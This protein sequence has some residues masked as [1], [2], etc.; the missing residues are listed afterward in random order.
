MKPEES[1][2]HLLGIT[3]SKAKMYEYDVPQEDHITVYRDPSNLFPLSIGLLGDLAAHLNSQQIDEISELKANLQF[4]AQFFD[5]FFQARLS[6]GL[7]PYLFLLGSAAYYLCDLPGSSSVLVKSLSDDGLD[8][9]CLGLE[10]LLL[11]LLKGKFTT[12]L[13]VVP[14][15]YEQNIQTLSEG[16]SRYFQTGIAPEEIFANASVL[17]GLAYEAGNPR[18]LLFA[19]VSV[20][21]TRKRV[22]NSTWFRLPEYSRLPVE[23]WS[24]TL[25]KSTFITEL[26]PGQRRLGE[27]GVF[28]GKSAIVQLPTSAGKTKATEILI[29][30]SFLAR[31][32]LLAVIVAPFRALCHEIRNDLVRAFKDEPIN[33]NEVSD[34][35]QPDFDLANITE[36]PQVLVV[37]PEKLVHVLRYNPELAQQIK[38]LIYD[39]GHQFDDQTRGVTYELLVTSL[40]Q[41]IPADAQTIL[42]SAVISNPDAIGTWLNGEDSLVIQGNDLTP[43]YRTLAFSSWVDPRGRLWFVDPANPDTEEF[44]V[45]RVIEQQTLQLKPRETAERVFPIRDDGSDVALFLGL[46]LVS[47]GSVAIFVGLK[48]SVGTLCRRAL[49]VY[50]RGLNIERP[51]NF[52]VQ[53]EIDRLTFLY[54]QNLGQNA[55]TAQSA[56]LGVFAHHNNIPQG[57]RLSV[58]YAVKNE[59]TKFVICTSTL[60]QGVNLPLRYLIVTSMYQGGEQIKVRDFHNLIGRAG[61]AGMFTE[62]SILFADPQIYLERNEDGWRWQTARSLL[63]RNN[64]E[65]ST[66]A[67]AQLLNPIEHEYDSSISIGPVDFVNAYIEGRVYEVLE[68]AIPESA[69]NVLTPAAFQ[70]QIDLRGDIIA[71]IES[72]LM[73]F[74][75]ENDQQLQQVEILRLA[76]ETLAYF[77]GGDDN[78]QQLVQIFG[79]LA[80]NIADKIPDSPKRKAFA[81]TFLG[82]KGSLSVEAWVADHIEALIAT[83]TQEEILNVLW[84]LI[85]QS[86][87]NSTA[88]RL[89]PAELLQ[90]IS[91][92]WIQGES[93]GDMLQPLEEHKAR[94]GTARNAPFVKVEH[95]VDICEN[96]F[97]FD[98]MLIVGAVTEVIQVVRPS[99]TD[100]LVRNLRAIQ[101]RLKYGLPAPLPI[102]IYEM[103]FADRILAMEL[104]S[105]LPVSSFLKEDILAAFNTNIEQVRVLLE[106]Y[107]SYFTIVLD[108]LPGRR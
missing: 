82:V 36:T 100:N 58:E 41:T 11:W 75:N 64:S 97:A 66:S 8:L 96:G 102:A 107:P 86:L 87:Q 45:P 92:R 79:I 10:N 55:I 48:D 18:Q 30:S 105:I 23:Q 83:D 50:E 108:E 85:S 77:L 71:A 57:I 28:S 91:V 24:A 98:S 93:F 89:N 34:V 70:D 78:K 2:R 81:R 9:G 7:D 51:A 49:D 76:S 26:W 3:R 15:P 65:A 43:T 32:S 53:N 56:A 35:L 37:T 13:N 59:L 104:S 33:V 20:A 103:G 106:K 84:D 12:A 67:L 44:Y 68:E 27:E 74:W 63:D 80:E 31:R 22:E 47:K 42:I 5:N 90:G 72:Y 101:K 62:G 60:A 6:Q 40:K 19:D 61:R 54:Q 25:A 16:V 29:R 4:S 21:V 14:G 38:L 52:S 46:K 95:L 94:I 73:T 69:R 99:G 88:R 17:R 1:S 39:E